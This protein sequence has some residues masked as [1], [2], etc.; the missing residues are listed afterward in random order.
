MNNSIVSGL[1]RQRQG[2]LGGLHFICRTASRP[3][4]ITFLF[5]VLL[6]SA[7]GANAQTLFDLAI[8]GTSCKAISDGSL[9]CKYQIGKDLELSITSVGE[10]DTGISFLRSDFDGDYF[11]RFGVM[12]GCIIVAR[13]MAAPKRGSAGDDFV[14]ISPKTGRIYK[15]WRECGSAT[16]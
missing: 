10:E 2:A 15:T 7:S 1:G 4:S 12:H 13:G 3:L 9:F 8:Q 6:A 16:K 5:C 14:F 11:A